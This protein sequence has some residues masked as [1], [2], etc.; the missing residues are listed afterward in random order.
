MNLN[1]ALIGTDTLHR[2]FIIKKLLELG[3]NLEMCIFQ[4]NILQPKFDTESSWADNEL[5]YLKEAFNKDIDLEINNINGI[6]YVEELN[7]LEVYE[8]I[9]SSDI[10]FFIVSGAGII[11]GQLLNYICNKAINVHLGNATQYRGL[12]TNLWAIYHKD[13]CNV[14]VTVHALQK[15]LDTGDIFFYS[16]LRLSEDIQI[17]MLRYYETK[18]ALDILYQACQAKSLGKL[19]LRKQTSIGRYYSFMPRAIKDSLPIL[20]KSDNF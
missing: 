2:R 18:L 1:V 13:Y 7:S 9:K 4:K 19:T 12:D 11:K 17:W 16:P 10:D 6:H 20:L 15:T 5:R 3:V 8:K 14:G